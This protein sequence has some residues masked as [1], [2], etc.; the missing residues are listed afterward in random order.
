[1]TIAGR[2][3]SSPG[4]NTAS[5]DTRDALSSPPAPVLDP[6]GGLDRV[7]SRVLTAGLYAAV[8]LLVVGVVLALVRS[9]IPVPR[10]SFL[11]GIPHALAGL[12]PGGFLNLG[13]LIL[14]VTP[15]ARVIALL[16]GFAW[17]RSW[18]FSLLSLLVLGVMGASAYLGIVV[19]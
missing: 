17:R 13:L 5:D 8:L 4:R 14:L 7:V 3:R 11:A 2:Y 6:D 19:G 9:G 1:M 16:V 15:A 18:L 12:E 10:E